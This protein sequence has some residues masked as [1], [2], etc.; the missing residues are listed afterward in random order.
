MVL[1]REFIPRASLYLDTQLKSD[2]CSCLLIV[3]PIG[4][5]E[6]AERWRLSWPQL[7]LDVRLDNLIA[8]IDT[9][10][11]NTTQT[12]RA[13][14]NRRPGE[15]RILLTEL[16]ALHHNPTAIRECAFSIAN[17]LLQIRDTWIEWDELEG[18]WRLQGR[19]VIGDTF[20]SAKRS[21]RWEVDRLINKVTTDYGV[22]VFPLLDTDLR[23]R[24]IRFCH[25]AQP[26][27]V[28]DVHG[29]RG[30]RWHLRWSELELDDDIG[31]LGIELSC[32]W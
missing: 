17:I 16:G 1:R 14:M 15:E 21:A 18:E 22:V 11:R 10:S 8:F 9:V 19:S 23:R 27:E 6:L 2:I 32:V 7:E 29:D 3:D 26:D 13:N 4:P 5:I 12:R 28:T 30:E 31:N 20:L 25:A 24:T